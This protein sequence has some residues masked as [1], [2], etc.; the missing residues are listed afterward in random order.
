M[1]DMKKSNPRPMTYEEADRV[2]ES[3][4]LIGVR[5]TGSRATLY[6]AWIYF[7]THDGLYLSGVIDMN[8]GKVFYLREDGTWR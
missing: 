6:A 8:N 2:V 5:P 3:A 1:K 7:F 4:R